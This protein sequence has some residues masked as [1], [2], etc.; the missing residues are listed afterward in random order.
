MARGVALPLQI[1]PRAG[2]RMVEHNVE[3]MIAAEL[4]PA[5]STNPFD[6]RDGLVGDDPTWDPADATT[7][8]R[9]RIHVNNVFDRFE[10]QGRAKL[11][12]LSF[13][14]PEVGH[15]LLRVR[16]TWDNLEQGGR[17]ETIREVGDA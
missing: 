6:Y 14:A 16:V 15:G 7:Q 11:V 5:S 2:L 12:D 17:H 9:I 8:G 3:T 4:L 13:D 10:R 1:T